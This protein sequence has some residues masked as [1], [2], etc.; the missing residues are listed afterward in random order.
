[1]PTVALR[2]Q[3]TSAINLIV[4]MARMRDGVRRITHIEEVVG[5][6]G[7]VI[8]TQTLFGYQSGA[9]DANGMLTGKFYCAGIRP[10]FLSQAQYFNRDKE[11]VECL[12]AEPIR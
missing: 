5:M 11:M 12:N 1:M 6:N 3:I 7:E 8:S 4:Q 2:H 9:M 10:R